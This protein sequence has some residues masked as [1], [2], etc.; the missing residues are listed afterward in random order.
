MGG[1]C[2]ALG[3]VESVNEV[4]I[5]QYEPI[6]AGYIE[7]HGADYRVQ[8]LPHGTGILAVVA[9]GKAELLGLAVE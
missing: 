5:E 9:G 8:I 6:G 2:Y 3:V 4:K 1:G 7:Q